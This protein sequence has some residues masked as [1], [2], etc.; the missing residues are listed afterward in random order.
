M[1]RQ[2][3]RMSSSP[4]NMEPKE[5]DFRILGFGRGMRRPQLN[6]WEPLRLGRSNLQLR[7]CENYVKCM[8]DLLL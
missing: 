1:T 5:E 7:F 8:C 6:V 4:S 2:S 3:V